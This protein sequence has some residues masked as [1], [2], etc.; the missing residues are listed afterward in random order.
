MAEIKVKNNVLVLVVPVAVAAVSHV[1]VFV[2]LY[3]SWFG[4]SNGTGGEFCEF[5]HEGLIKQPTNTFSN[6]GFMLAGLIAAFQ[7][8]KGKFLQNNNPLTRT[9]FFPIVLCSLIILLSPGSMAMHASETTIGGYF[10]M[11]SMYLIAAIIFSYAALRLFK[12]SKVMYT[13]IFAAVLVVC[14]IFHYSNWEPPLVGFAG[15]FIFG[16]F[17]VSGVVFELLHKIIN[18]PNIEFEWVIFASITFI[19]AFSV[20]QIGWDQHP[21]CIP[22]AIVQAHGIWH[23]LDALAIYCFFRLYVSED[24]SKSE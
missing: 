15:S 2:G 5:S 14:H 24:R 7:V 9:L 18:K 17:C 13:A 10:D 16:I 23:I 21:W 20:W 8:Y 11:L 3:F 12:L 6:F 1:L 19:V 4:V 22:N